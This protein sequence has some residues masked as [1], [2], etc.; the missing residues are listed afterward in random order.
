M[1]L[2][3][4]VEL[5]SAQ[6]GLELAFYRVWLYG[7]GSGWSLL[8]LV[9]YWQRIHPP[10]ISPSNTH[11]NATPD[12]GKIHPSK[13]ISTDVRRDGHL[14]YFTVSQPTRGVRI[15]LRYGDCG[16]STVNVL[17]FIVSA[18]RTSITKRLR[19]DPMATRIESP[20]VNVRASWCA[21]C[22][23]RL[24]SKC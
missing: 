3:L 5:E 24:T 1:L 2:F 6:P 15:E 20:F 18:R 16:I 12:F 11:T 8:Y 19:E 10:P 9:E 21:A 7:S 22:F 17:D 4:A 14:L 23:G 13:P